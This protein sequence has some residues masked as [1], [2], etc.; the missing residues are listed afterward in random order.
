[1]RIRAAEVYEAQ[2]RAKLKEHMDAVGEYWHIGHLA[3]EL[4]VCFWYSLLCMISFL[5]LQLPK[6]EKLPVHQGLWS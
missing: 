1:M 5:S 4:V 6:M 2:E 3:N